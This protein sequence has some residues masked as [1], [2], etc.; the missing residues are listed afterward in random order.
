MNSQ[1][2]EMWIFWQIF[3][4]IYSNSKKYEIKIWK[5][6]YKKIIV[7]NPDSN[8]EAIEIILR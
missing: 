6:I 3:L 2:V 4:N 1:N 7:P 5:Y 8:E